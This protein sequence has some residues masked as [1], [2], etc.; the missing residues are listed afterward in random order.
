M[1]P[2]LLEDKSERL[3]LRIQE[4]S[5]ELAIPPAKVENFISYTKSVNRASECLDELTSASAEQN[6]LMCLM[7]QLK[8]SGLDKYRQKVKGISSSVALLKD[9][10]QKSNA[11]YDRNLGN[12]RRELDFRIKSC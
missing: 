5:T 1:I 7:E 10:I 11:S 12:F 3:G 8:L 9:Q 4:F 2:K 6:E